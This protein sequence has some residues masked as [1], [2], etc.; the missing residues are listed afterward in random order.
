MPLAVPEGYRRLDATSL[1]PYLASLPAIAS[2]LGGSA[3]DW[4]AA[5]ASDGNVNQVFLVDGPTG[6]VCVKQALPY[7]KMAGESWP[8]TLE[9]VRFE[10]QAL[11]EHGRHVG[12]RVPDVYHYDP[13]LYLVIIERLGPH[14]L[15]REGTLAGIRYPRLA[16]DLA[17]YLAR[18][19]FFTSSLGLAAAEKK[20]LMALFCA[21]VELCRIMEDVFFT[22]PYQLHA[23][24]R[25]T[26]PQLDGLAAEVRADVSLKLA[27]AR[28][29]LKYMTSAEALIH[30]DLHAGSILVT[31][32]DT[33][34]IDHEFAFYGPMGFDVGTVIANLMV[35][36]FS[37]DGHSTAEEP[38]EDYQDWLLETVEAL[39]CRFHAAFVAL[40]EHHACDEAYPAALFSD[41]AGRA[42][43][44]AERRDRVQGVLADALG[45]A[46]VEIF[47]RVLGVAHII[48]LERIA[49]PERRAACEARCAALARDL[50]VNT[51]SYG[52]ISDVVRAARDLRRPRAT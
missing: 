8:L 10:H 15:L 38:R 23:R 48:D 41:P 45:F 14:I 7:V 42:A 11:I 18:S 36:Y 52:A 19:L 13:R 26:S 21:N 44:A 24:N 29:K 50:M 2:R 35:S 47:R 4:R 1:F 31:P 46:G 40:W 6:A 33:R 12:R 5:E 28:L 51:G 39:W 20:R 32:D 3:R 30:G 25:W 9:R 43:L 16:E 22:E 27:A 34:V 49:D 17:Q 37:Q